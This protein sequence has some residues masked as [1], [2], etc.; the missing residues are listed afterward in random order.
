[1]DFSSLDSEV[2]KIQEALG[3]AGNA[4]ASALDSVKV[5]KPEIARLDQVQVTH[6]EKI[7]VL[8]G[9]ISSLKVS[10]CMG[11]SKARLLTI[12]LSKH[13]DYCRREGCCYFKEARRG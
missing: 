10:G 7:V 11:S 2:G 8:D 6:G 1:M 12:P 13:T 4:F 3:G 5:F 9:S